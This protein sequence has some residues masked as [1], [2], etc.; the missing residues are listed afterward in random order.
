MAGKKELVLYYRPQGA[1]N[2]A[3]LKSVLV[4]MGIRIRNVQA[5]QLDQKI[6]FLTGMEGYEEQ[7]ERAE[8]ETLPRGNAGDA[9]VLQC[10]TGRVFKTAEKSGSSLHCTESSCDCDE[11]GMEP[12]GTVSGTVPGG[13]G[14]TETERR[15]GRAAEKR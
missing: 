4:R 7:E 12:A 11:C 1:P 15:T 8:G 13:R 10:Q 5:E 6:G 2:A 3:K 9:S 14:S